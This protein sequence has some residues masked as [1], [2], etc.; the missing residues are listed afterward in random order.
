MTAEQRVFKSQWDF[1]IVNLSNLGNRL[2]R[3]LEGAASFFYFFLFFGHFS[4]ETEKKKKTF[5][6]CFHFMPFKL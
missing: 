4:G 3:Q 1:D 2:L 6:S 5:N